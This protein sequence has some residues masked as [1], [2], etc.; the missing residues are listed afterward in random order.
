VSNSDDPGY[1]GEHL[2][3]SGRRRAARDPAGQHGGYGPGPDDSLRW[4]G[5]AG[6]GGIAA[7]LRDRLGLA[8]SGAAHGNGG[9]PAGNGRGYY[10]YDRGAWDR[11]GPPGPPGGARPRPSRQAPPRGH[12]PQDP[13]LRDRFH[14]DDAYP[15]NGSGP[16][17]RYHQGE[18][19]PGRG[20]PPDAGRRRGLRDRGRSALTDS[21][22][23][24]T[25]G[26]R[27]LRNFGRSGRHQG[28]YPP[29]GYEPGGYP[30]PGYGPDGY[31]GDGYPGDAY[32]AGAYP[33]AYPPAGGYGDDADHL[34]GGGPGR[35]GGRGDRGPSGG[36][37][38]KVKGSWWRHWT[39]KKALAV[40]GCAGLLVV[41]LLVAG[42]AYA[43]SRTTIP[44][45]VSLLARQQSSV[46]YLSDGKTIVGQFSQ[47]G[48]SRQVLSDSQ[49]PA[50]MK[51]AIIAAEDRHFYT[52]GGVS[53]TGIMRAAYEDLTGG[54]YQGG[55]TITEELVKAYYINT[56]GN[57]TV[58]EK[59]KEILIAIKLAHEKSKDWILT[60][61]LNVAPFGQNTYGVAAAAQAYFNEPASKL[62]VSQAAMLAAMVNE[63]GFFDP[64]PKTPGYAPLVARWRYVLTNMVRD[65]AITQAQASAQKFPKI[66][67]ASQNGW[68]GWKGYVMQAV[69]NE[70]LNTY[71]YTQEEIDTDGLKIVTTINP[72]MM[73]HLYRSVSYEKR[74]MRALLGRPL[75][76]WLRI[77][78]VLEKPGTGAILAMYGGPGYG[79]RHCARYNCQYNMAMQA[80]EQVGSSFKPYVLATAVQQGMNVQTSK[81]FDIGPACVPTDYYPKIPSI[82]AKSTLESGCPQ[83]TPYGYQVINNDTQG[84][85]PPVGVAQA[86]A[87][88]IN[89]AYTDLWHRVGGKNVID[90][91]KAFGV[92]VQAASLPQFEH[93]SGLA[94]GQGSLTL[95]EQA[96]MIATL[97]ADGEY[98]TP[99]VIAKLSQNGKDIP[100]KIVHRRVLSPAAAAD[101]D[102]AMSF[103]NVP[104]Y[105]GTAYP[106][107]AW[108]GR[109]VIAKTG[110]TGTNV[111]P[112][113][114]ALFLGAIPQY[115]LSVGAFVQDPGKTY[116]NLDFLPALNGQAGQFGGTWP[117][118]IWDQFMT[119]EFANLPVRPLPT[120]DFNGF[121]TWIQEKAVKPHKKPQPPA[122]RPCSQNGPPWQRCHPS[123]NPTPTPTQP[124]PTTSQSPS[125]PAPSCTPPQKFCKTSPPAGGVAAADTAYHAGGSALAQ[126][127]LLIPAAVA[128]PVLLA[129]IAAA[130]RR[131]RPGRRRRS[132]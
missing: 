33:D 97:A 51:Q 50:D 124:I 94:L 98:A 110:T 68:T 108:P 91:A 105:G 18:Y 111:Q 37:R 64:T 123:P 17:G 19:E 122:H 13:Y 119:T 4:A 126:A 20:Y 76:S 75:P 77:G 87:Q 99:H 128:G 71:G 46:V 48:V 102:Y 130:R 84:H 83:N 96:T 120:P 52:E 106:A 62:T 79:V 38:P 116:E 55:S 14:P 42:F 9:G 34:P 129:P 58:K 69:D 43:Y 23:A 22:A 127:A 100:L 118:T 53:I 21:F 86:M 66:T 60:Q 49:I 16:G 104:N 36:E 15:S 88:S 10:G 61:F 26:F 24:I 78:A 92:D 45:T 131:K 57:L 54:S 2:P 74:R 31:P 41:L 112:A 65:G 25:D 121:Q 3:A 125:P 114:S 47:N 81:L 32:P 29:L 35:P 107:A 89:S 27:S 132:G 59:L 90:M 95:E 5:H 28:G 30:A 93:E 11:E 80:R 7:G 44:S 12:P 8:G 109:P 115:A 72:A 117:A 39:W 85:F 101:V 40:V 67:S 56:T 70:L 6:S 73:R 82:P 63:P 103:D 113:P 1:W